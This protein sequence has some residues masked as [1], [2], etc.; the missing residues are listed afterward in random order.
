[1]QKLSTGFKG[2]FYVAIIDFS[3]IFVKQLLSDL[4]ETHLESVPTRAT[5]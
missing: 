1:L 3:L 2:S 4:I 5:N